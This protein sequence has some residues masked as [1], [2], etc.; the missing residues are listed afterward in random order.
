MKIFSNFKLF[1]TCTLILTSAAPYSDNVISCLHRTPKLFIFITTLISVRL[2]HT[3]HHKSTATYI[4]QV[5]LPFVLIASEIQLRTFCFKVPFGLKGSPCAVQSRK[6]ATHHRGQCTTGCL[7]PRC[8]LYFR[9]G[10]WTSSTYQ[11]HTYLS[12]HSLCHHCL[13]LY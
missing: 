2:Q 3:K 9:R 11:K 13:S 5:I 10:V 8:L 12:Q 4:S 7:I 1:Y 6:A